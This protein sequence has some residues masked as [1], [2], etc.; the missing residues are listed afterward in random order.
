MT[1][2]LIF[3]LVFGIMMEAT[4]GQSTKGGAITGG[5][6]S[7][8]S[9]KGGSY[10]GSSFNGGGFKGGSFFSTPNLFNWGN[11][12]GINNLFSGL[13][14]SSNS[15]YSNLGDIKFGSG[16]I[17][18]PPYLGPSQG[19]KGGSSLSI[20][21]GTVKG[22]TALYAGSVKGGATFYPNT[23][24][25]VISSPYSSENTTVYRESNSVDY[26]CQKQYNDVFNNYN[27]DNSPMWDSLKQKNEGYMIRRQEMDMKKNIDNLLVE[28]LETAF[29]I[30][31]TAANSSYYQLEIPQ[32]VEKARTSML[33]GNYAPTEALLIK[34]SVLSHQKQDI[35][36][37]MQLYHLLSKFYLATGDTSKAEKF[38]LDALFI[39]EHKRC[40]NVFPVAVMSA[41]NTPAAILLGKSL[42]NIP[43]VPNYVEKTESANS[44]KKNGIEKVAAI[45]IAFTHT[46]KFNIPTIIKCYSYDLESEL[47]NRQLQTSALYSFSYFDT[48]LIPPY[49]LYESKIEE[50]SFIPEPPYSL[51]ESK[52]EEPSFIPEPPYSLDES[53]IEK[54]NF[55]PSF[56]PYSPYGY[57]RSL[58]QSKIEAPKEEDAFET[59]D[60]KWHFILLNELVSLYLGKKD[61]SKAQAY[62]QKIVAKLQATTT[63]EYVAMLNNMGLIYLNMQKYKQADSLFTK[64]FDLIPTC[65][66]KHKEMLYYCNALKWEGL[67]ASIIR[68]D[69]DGNLLT[70]NSGLKAY[71]NLKAAMIQGSKD[72]CMPMNLAYKQIEGTRYLQNQIIELHKQ[73]ILCHVNIGHL[74]WLQNNLHF[75]KQNYRAAYRLCMSETT[76]RDDYADG[77]S[78]AKSNSPMAIQILKS[79][80]IISE[81]KQSFQ[82]ASTYWNAVIDSKLEEYQF[83]LGC[84]SEDEKQNY[85]ST[86]KSEIDAYFNLSHKLYY[87]RGINDMRLYQKSVKRAFSYAANSKSTI[88]DEMIKMRNVIEKS[89]NTSLINTYNE[90]ISL[91]RE[92]SNLVALPYTKD[93]DI[94]SYLNK[95]KDSLSRVER[96][97]MQETH[98][99]SQNKA[100]AI[101]E[102][103]M[104]QVQHSLKKGEVAIEII[105]F[106]STQFKQT[107]YVALIATPFQCKYVPLPNGTNNALENEW[108]KYYESQ[109][110][111]NHTDTTSYYRYWEPIA[112][113]IEDAKTVYIS[114]DGIYHK[115]NLNTLMDKNGIYIIEKWNI[116]VIASTRDLIGRDRTEKMP[117][118]PTAIL[119][120][121]PLF[122]LSQQEMAAK[123]K[124]I[125]A[126]NP[127]NFAALMRGDERGNFQPLAGAEAEI[128]AIDKLLQANGWQTGKYLGNE[129]LEDR[130]KYLPGKSP[131]VLALATHGFFKPAK[132]NSAA[133]D[134]N[135]MY[136]SGLYLAGAQTSTALSQKPDA[137]QFYTKPESEDGIMY[138]EEASTLNLT[139]TQ[140]VILSACETGLG[141]IQNGEG[142]YGLQ[143]AF[144]MAGAKNLLMSLWK[145]EDEATKDLMTTFFTYW[146]EKKMSKY[147]A[148]R[149]A[150]LDLLQKHKGCVKYWGGFIMMES[151]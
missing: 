135:P 114:N 90:Y 36:L 146:I 147:E 37:N 42:W 103:Y 144:R 25:Y 89:N 28:G 100:I 136:Q 4:F 101:G 123:A 41:P 17:A 58:S 64:A 120:G 12:T 74:Q 54:R 109:I 45:N 113:A 133:Y 30:D 99:L 83:N 87:K 148:F 108:L 95:M 21:S 24:P 137:P 11:G 78:I 112:K 27:K 129:A 33:R 43:V 134:N 125:G 47:P 131:T 80:A 97:I 138:A 88:L 121:N 85:F 72:I 8:T 84:L 104:H 94:S 70:H 7:G 29:S 73:K 151:L 67:N 46:P 14:S 76:E 3:L 79:L 62:N 15:S 63:P 20:Y 38:A 98:L 102:K 55:P 96:R 18:L 22:G 107:Q 116:H 32:Q 110:A 19:T 86:L 71:S 132:G 126:P 9:F 6:Y 44:S 122:S 59:T 48:Y 92:I 10:S 124:Q 35:F 106:Y 130:L 82:T 61:F 5:G 52:T 149:Q 91:K 31:R 141:A 26:S 65:I 16:N 23:S 60:E 75:A 145:V 77:L 40:K 143:R 56:I 2:Q 117:E 128:M 142:V 150:Q 49:S 81:Q 53:K 140:L 118:N 119:M 127:P 115:L 57:Y 34:I 93:V 51:Y 69:S 105:K 66:R 39:V 50:P 1:K 139:E 13:F 68:Y 111:G